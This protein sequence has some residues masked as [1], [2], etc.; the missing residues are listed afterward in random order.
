MKRKTRRFD[1]GGDTTAEFKRPIKSTDDAKSETAAAPKKISFSS[2]FAAARR[3]GDKTFEW[4]GKK[5][6]TALKGENKLVAKP[7]AKPASTAS[8]N[9]DYMTAGP[10]FKRQGEFPAAAA[11]N[12]LTRATGIATDEGRAG[13]AQAYED[14]RKKA[15][16]ERKAT[17]EQTQAGG[18]TDTATLRRSEMDAS[19]PVDEMRI[20]SR[21]H[22]VKR[23]ATG[24]MTSS[25]SKRADGIAQKGK[26]R[27]KIY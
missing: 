19:L 11:A 14:A 21:D 2:A 26:T 15:A 22:S 16:A 18:V 12:R 3:A 1:E 25:A 23:M 4:E 13:K 17:A 5:Y 8:Y 10:E 9:D 7:A 27:G 24:G 20:Y 6:G